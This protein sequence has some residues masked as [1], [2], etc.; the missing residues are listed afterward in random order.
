MNFDSEIIRKFANVFEN[1]TT[2]VFAA[3]TETCGA[4]AFFANMSLIYMS[5]FGSR[6]ESKIWDDPSNIQPFWDAGAILNAHYNK[7][8]IVHTEIYNVHVAYV[9]MS[10][11]F[12]ELANLY[13][14]IES[15]WYLPRK[16]NDNGMAHNWVYTEVVLKILYINPY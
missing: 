7:N 10:V 12:W 6:D 9:G 14:W 11:P 1:H 15:F 16:V 13:L 4:V 3:I 2:C 8:T 5:A